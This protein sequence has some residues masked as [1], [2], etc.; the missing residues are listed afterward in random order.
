MGDTV[1][2]AARRV[3]GALLAAVLVLGMVPQ[4]ALAADEYGTHVGGAAR[5]ELAEGGTLGTDVGV[6]VRGNLAVETTPARIVFRSPDAL[7]DADRFL[8][9]TVE[10]GVRITG[11]ASGLPYT[12][13]WSRQAYDTATGQYADEPAGSPYQMNR[14]TTA[15][16]TDA[17]MSMTYD[18]KSDTYKVDTLYRYTL[19]VT[20]GSGA[21]ATNQIEV[22]CGNEYIYGTITNGKGD[23]REGAQAA[24]DETT[25]VD[26]TAMRLWDSELVVTELGAEGRS[27]LYPHA[28]GNIMD[29]AVN[30]ALVSESATPTKPVFIVPPK[31]KLAFRLHDQSIE[32]GWPVK[33]LAIQGGRVVTV[34]E[35]DAV[36]EVDAGGWKVARVGISD[37]DESGVDALGV[38]AVT[39]PPAGGDDDIVAVT[40]QVGV[41]VGIDGFGEGV[42]GGRVAPAD[43]AV[44]YAIGSQVRYTMTPDEGFA[45]DFATLGTDPDGAK[46]PRVSASTAGASAGMNFVDLTVTRPASGDA[47]FLTAYFK[48]AGSPTPPVDP[49]PDVPDPDVPDVPDDPMRTFTVQAT[50][51]AGGSISPDGTF[52]VRIGE[53]I[54]FTV[55]PE[56]GFASDAVVVNGREVA[57]ERQPG[58]TY[59]F[60]VS[61]VQSDLRVHATFKES[62]GSH[63]TERPIAITVGSS[64]PGLAH[65]DGA[66]E[67]ARGGSFTVTLVPDAGCRLLKL[68]RDGR[69]V[70]SEVAA[71]LTYRI[72]DVQAATRIQA[73]FS[74]AAGATDP[75][76][77]DS[78]LITTRV[79]LLGEVGATG[80]AIGGHVEPFRAQVGLGE[81]Q[82]FVVKPQNGS[83]AAW[84]KM[85]WTGS[86]G[87]MQERTLDL[88]ELALPTGGTAPE[89]SVLKPYLYVDVPAEAEQV[90]LTVAFDDCTRDPA[91][92]GDEN[93]V[94]PDQPL[95]AMQH[96]VDIE[97]VCE[98]GV[99][100]IVTA[101]RDGELLGEAPSRVM[102]EHDGLLTLCAIPYGG[103]AVSFEVDDADALVEQTDAQGGAPA[104]GGITGAAGTPVPKSWLVRA[105]AHVRVV[106]TKQGDFTPPVP[107]AGTTLIQT[108]T[109]GSGAITPAFAS[110]AKGGPAAAFTIAPEAG[111]HIASLVLYDQTTGADASAYLPGVATAGGTIELPYLG[112]RAY[113]LVA[114]FGK[115][116]QSG[117]GP[118]APVDPDDPA[119]DAIE[120]TA[121]VGRDLAQYSGE[122][123]VTIEGSD[124]TDAAGNPT[125]R[126]KT[127]QS[128]LVRFM[129]G[130]NSMLAYVTIASGGGEPREVSVLG[131][132][133]QVTAGDA[134]L[135]VTA[136]F[137]YGTFIDRTDFAITYEQ[138]LSPEECGW[139]LTA[140]PAEKVGYGDAVRVS[141]LPVEGSER[142][143]DYKLVSLTVN[144]VE[145]AGSLAA[146]GARTADS[147]GRIWGSFLYPNVT[148][149]THAVAT[150]AYDPQTGPDVPDVP[151]D[152]NKPSD[153]D[154]PDNPNKP[155]DPNN[156]DDP[157]D[158]N[159]PG[160]SGNPSGPNGN[161]GGNGNG[162]GVT[163]VTVR[164]S[165]AGNGTI[166]PS[167]EMRVVAGTAQPFTLKPAVGFQPVAVKIITSEGE[168]TVAQTTTQFTLTV[169]G[170]TEV[171]AYFATQAYPGPNDAASRAIRRLTS[172]AQTGDVQAA[173]AL[174]LVAVACAAGGFALIS[175]RRKRADEAAE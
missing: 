24:D 157:N 31:V 100:G 164:A 127:G 146:P 141:V 48:H 166:E 65:P 120:L 169:T 47:L 60:T 88:R 11:A 94:Y 80:A 103:Y 53:D 23:K 25:V 138:N 122:G 139:Q 32:E 78:A 63:V 79:E 36:V 142:A 153:P 155:D 148:E 116:G 147:T 91:N 85:S 59:T 99:G 87:S 170:D 73:T 2:M 70:T 114:T 74:D 77:P 105:D 113:L 10:G 29:A 17:G 172:L 151:D 68:T 44:P 101:A 152:P 5:A 21:V 49:D 175:R 55:V 22:F 39:Y 38:F 34:S 7:T 174:A 4:A 15:E 76:V 57:L 95:P 167:G 171:V 115:D 86:D 158:P 30:V 9:S 33:V 108:L 125:V 52:L 27:E 64:G 18:L 83:Y 90:L 126:L 119:A 50:A 168:R 81:V 69:D 42:A 154:N 75:I 163:Y 98:D 6:A 109:A 12:Y 112:E 145:R 124:A 71:N 118:S 56:D 137:K 102:M 162:N 41:P 3:W 149:D 121:K 82:R 117:E 19:T 26:V 84:A 161:G 156:P 110:V 104:L 8:V 28:Q 14:V 136:Y 92:P 132:S 159:N 93:Y 16:P 107:D 129:P 173:A 46:N 45:F 97:V 135:V 66:S 143:R 20:D 62:P 128:A 61:N 35:P 144:G 43:D 72:D 165:S 134:D 133:L 131:S 58:G 160:N 51:G 106:F 40:S 96:A 67:V 123:S 150:F 54:T 140:S 89:G 111:W 13:T 1:K 130:A 37:V